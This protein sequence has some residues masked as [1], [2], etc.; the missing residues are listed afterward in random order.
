[1]YIPKTPKEENVHSNCLMG[2]IFLTSWR[3]VPS[4]IKILRGIWIFK[5][6]YAKVSDLSLVISVQFCEVP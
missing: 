6:L 1:M 4:K 2:L 5:I 3:I